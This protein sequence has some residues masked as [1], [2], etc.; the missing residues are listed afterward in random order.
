MDID[1]H[2]AAAALGRKGGKAGKGVPKPK[3]AANLAKARAAITPEQ[4]AVACAKARAAK[5]AKRAAAARE[6][7]I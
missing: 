6:K 3:S 2:N 7:G 4:R 1:I 5:A